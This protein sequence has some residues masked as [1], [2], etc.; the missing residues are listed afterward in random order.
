MERR[1]ALERATLR[2]AALA[3][4]YGASLAFAGSL[5]SGR[6]REVRRA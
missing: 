4:K 2:D 1:E 3:A 6:C 5:R